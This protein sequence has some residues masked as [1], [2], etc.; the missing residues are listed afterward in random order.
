MLLPFQIYEI[1]S[2]ALDNL[3]AESGQ[4][5]TEEIKSK[6]QER[7]RLLKGQD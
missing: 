6:T 2:F 4:E 1:H 5:A 3:V 7:L